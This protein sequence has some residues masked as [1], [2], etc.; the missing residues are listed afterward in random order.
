[1]SYRHHLNKSD[2]RRALCRPA[3]FFLAGQLA[4]CSTQELHST[5]ELQPEPVREEEHVKPETTS[6]SPSEKAKMTEQYSS[7]KSQPADQ[8]KTQTSAQ[9][10]RSQAKPQDETAVDFMKQ[11]YSTD[12]PVQKKA[13]HSAGTGSK[14]PEK[15]KRK[16]PADS[17]AVSAQDNSK[18]DADPERSSSS[19]SSR[20][21]NK[22]KAEQK[23]KDP[24][25]SIAGD[26]PSTSKSKLESKPLSRGGTTVDEHQDV[27]SD[28]HHHNGSDGHHHDGTGYLYPAKKTRFWNMQRPQHSNGD[29]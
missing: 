7:N 27:N 17:S 23:S 14:S 18:P 11:K 16:S 21:K 3:V 5:Q 6:S 13:E 2:I 12:K 29:E 24:Q 19:A 4:A 26:A 9:S 8:P 20:Q 10:S 15:T 25:T 28:T 22:Q 1:M